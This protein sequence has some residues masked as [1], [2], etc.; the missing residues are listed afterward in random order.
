MRHIFT[1]HGDKPLLTPNDLP[2]ATNAVLEDNE[3]CGQP[4][5]DD[6]L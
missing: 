2:F 1:R 5:E 4:Q 6:A 3:E